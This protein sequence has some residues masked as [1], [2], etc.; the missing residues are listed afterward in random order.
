M[1]SNVDILTGPSSE[2][3]WVIRQSNADM[4]VS[5]LRWLVELLILARRQRMLA[6][7]EVVTARASSIAMVVFIMCVILLVLSN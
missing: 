7:A 6:L 2:T 5:S 3:S 1:L 4:L